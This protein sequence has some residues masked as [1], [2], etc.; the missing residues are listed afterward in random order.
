[1]TFIAWQHKTVLTKRYKP[2]EATDSQQHRTIQVVAGLHWLQGNARPYW[3]ITG[4]DSPNGSSGSIH[5]KILEHWPELQPI[6]DLHMSNDH[7]APMHAV[8]NAEY[9]AG[10]TEWLNY[11]RKVLARHLRIAPF[12]A[13]QLVREIAAGDMT[14]TEFVSMQQDRWTKE[15]LAAMALLKSLQN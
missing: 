6:V 15:S 11:D 1:M 12:A 8:A 5:E 7:G 14:M 2:A 9:W 13:D 3:S 4:T 10:L